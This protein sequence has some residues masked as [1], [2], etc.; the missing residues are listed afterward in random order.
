MNWNRV[1]KEERYLQAGREGLLHDDNYV[2][3]DAADGRSVRRRTRMVPTPALAEPSSRYHVVNLTAEAS[4][5]WRA[6]CSCGWTFGPAKNSS[7]KAASDA[8]ERAF[9]PSASGKGRS[10]DT[11]Q[12]GPLNPSTQEQGTDIGCHLCSTP[13]LVLRRSG[14][15]EPVGARCIR[16]KSRWALQFY[17]QQTQDWLHGAG[18]PTA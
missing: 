6:Q 5:K 9:P 8:H 4:R 12:K 2:G 18:R 15:R 3:P 11:A 7:T 10:R 1:Q 17:D 13:L 14:S 16:C